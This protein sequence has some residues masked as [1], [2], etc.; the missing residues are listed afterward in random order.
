MYLSS[1]WG[2]GWREICTAAQSR[3]LR[4]SMQWWQEKWQEPISLPWNSWLKCA[5]INKACVHI[6]CYKQTQ[7][8]ADCIPDPAGNRSYTYLSK[9]KSAQE[10]SQVLELD[11]LLCSVWEGAPG[12]LKSY[13]NFTVESPAPQGS[14]AGTT[15]RG[16]IP[17]DHPVLETERVI[18][19]A[20]F[21]PQYSWSCLIY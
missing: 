16:R 8:S 6:S 19:P 14:A 13:A 1:V 11:H 2:A 20:C 7:E 21:T 15:P 10:C 3:P 4:T 17:W 9:L 12:A 18:P 5:L